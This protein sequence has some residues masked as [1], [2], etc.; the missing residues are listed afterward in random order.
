MSH[1]I[2]SFSLNISITIK[3]SLL[4][5]G[6]CQ[7]TPSGQFSSCCMPSPF[8]VMYKHTNFCCNKKK[9]NFVS[10]L[11]FVRPETRFHTSFELLKSSHRNPL[12]TIL[13]LTALIWLLRRFRQY[14]LSNQAG[15]NHCGG[16]CLRTVSLVKAVEF[17]KTPIRQNLGH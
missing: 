11:I 10:R 16:V 3:T 9:N 17:L 12:R 6:H 4:R 15:G 13:S 5:L 1:Q 14:C 2:L 7:W 8:G